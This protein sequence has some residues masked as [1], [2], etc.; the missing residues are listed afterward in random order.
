[1]ARPFTAAATAEFYAQQI[2]GIATDGG[3][4]RG[5]D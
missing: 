3:M 2:E 5:L 4:N 1:L